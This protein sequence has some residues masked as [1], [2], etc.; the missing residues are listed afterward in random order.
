M[1]K[2]KRAK[3]RRRRWPL[4]LGLVVA[5]LLVGVGAFVV[6][7]LA[8][9]GA[10]RRI[11]PR[12]EGSC[13]PVA[14]PLGPEDIEVDRETGLA[15]VSSA[16]FRA[17]AAGR[18]TS[19]AIYSFDPGGGAGPV[20]LETDLEG[21]FNPHGIS[22]WRQEGELRLFAVS[23]LGGGQSRVEV[24][25]V[26][27]GRLRHLRTVS[28]PSMVS[29]N[30]VAAA[31]PDRFY[32]TNDGGSRPDSAMRTVESYLRL[33]WASVVYFDG[34]RA[35]S[36]V[37]GLVYANGV[38]LS[39]DGGT[40]YVAESS[41]RRLSSYSR[42]PETGGLALRDERRFQTGLDNISVAADGSVWIAAHP[43][44]LDFVAHAEDPSRLSPSQ[45]LRVPVA[46]GRLGEPEEVYLGDGRELSG[47]SVAAPLE[48]RFLVGAVFEH[49]F[50]DCRL[51]AVGP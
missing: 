47:S 1:A 33:P 2:A 7:L 35:R 21:P 41:G 17:L 46:D 25:A 14:G 42:D 49:H 32:F 20:R 15:Y 43:K 40:V 27:A 50:L 9:A 6:D 39:A 22:L 3:G 38:A 36:V 18:P 48:G 44:L 12:F 23:H 29:P 10:F 5:A 8:D 4:V 31:G 11:E 19:G 24:F 45:V 13:R 30:D 51:D 16:D 26:E 28:D 34:D 37:E